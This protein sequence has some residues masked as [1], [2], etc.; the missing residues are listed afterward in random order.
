MLHNDATMQQ[1]QNVV[2]SLNTCLQ[3]HTGKVCLAI[4][5]LTISVTNTCIIIYKRYY[6][7]TIF[8]NCE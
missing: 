7:K 1:L 8:L 5:R 2:C 4:R 6:R 3:S